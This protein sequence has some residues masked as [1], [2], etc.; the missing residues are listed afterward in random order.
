[1]TPLSQYRPPIVRLPPKSNFEVVLARGSQIALCSLGLLGL[2]FALKAGQYI[3]APVALAVVIGL[4]L[5]P[6]ATRIE[7]R[8]VRPALSSAVVLLVFFLVIGAL[9][10]A[11]TAPLMYWA[12]RLPQIWDALQLQISQFREPL[13]LL[14]DM[15][16]QIRSMTGDENLTVSVEDGSPVTSVAIL[17]PTIAAQIL[18]FVASLYFFLAT[19]NAL[20]ITILR[21]VVK[22]KLRWRVAH[23]FRDVEA[24]VSRYLLSITAINVILGVAVTVAMW[25]IG[26]PQPALWGALAGILNYIVYIGP[27]LI[28]VMLFA[29][30]L[31]SFDTLTGSML[32]PAL[33]LLLNLIESQF[34]TPV[35]VGRT[36]TLNP[37]V[38]FLTLTFWLWIW[39]PI[40]GFI[41]IPALLIVLAI[42]RNIIPA[43]NLLLEPDHPPR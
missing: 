32:P 11:L 19:R 20:R 35:V 16:E 30:G 1:M 39:G 14:G 36:T 18:V 41:A 22:R 31:A 40:G 2:V 5:G 12:G 24:L 21:M 13:R 37:F 15:R 4:M 25:A 28:T 33:Y 29:I 38:V 6:I 42:G 26:L 27:A 7:A 10:A 43:I 17:A 8:G 9:A 34:I 23:I 3:L